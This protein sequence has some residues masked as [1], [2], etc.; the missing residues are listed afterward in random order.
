MPFQPIPSTTAQR[1]PKKMSN[2]KKWETSVV[3]KIALR[4]GIIDQE[5][6]QD[7]ILELEISPED[8]S[9]LEILESKTNIDAK[10]FKNLK[11]MVDFALSQDKD[12]Q[13]D[14][15]LAQILV[16]VQFLTQGQLEN[17]LLEQKRRLNQT[18]KSL[19]LEHIL[20]EKGFISEERLQSVLQMMAK[21]PLQ[22]EECGTKY[23]WGDFHNTNHARCQKCDF[24]LVPYLEEEMDEAATLVADESGVQNPPSQ[25]SIEQQ[26]TLAA[27]ETAA[28]D[29]PPHKAVRASEG[30]STHSPAGTDSHD[31][32]NLTSAET[33]AGNKIDT[34]DPAAQTSGGQKGTDPFI[35]QVLGEVKL[36]KK[37]GQ[38]GMGAVYLGEHLHLARQEAIKIL[39][40]EFANNPEQVTRF[41]R[42]ARAAGTLD[43]PHI[44]RVHH[45]GEHKGIHYISMEF[46]KGCSLQ[47]IVNEKK[48][49][50]AK[51][52]IEYMK[53]AAKGLIV[54]HKKDIVHRDIKPD[55]LMVTE[56]GVVKVADF[57]LARKT[58]DTMGVTQ[59]GS[60]LGTPYFM[61]P[62][63]C[64]GE[65]TDIR[66]DI[67]SLG[68]T[69]YY[70]LT[71]QHPFV[72]DSPM[73]ILL[74][75]IHEEVP[76][77][78]KFA[79]EVPDSLKN[80]I[81][82]M[83]EKL[84]EDRYQTLEEFLEDIKKLEEGEE[85]AMSEGKRRRIFRRR[86]RRAIAFALFVAVVVFLFS[87]KPGQSEAEIR[88]KLYQEKLQQAQQLLTAGDLENAIEQFEDARKQQNTSEIRHALLK[89]Y[90]Q[91]LK[92]L[93][94]KADQ[95][96][97][98]LPKTKEKL[99]QLLQQAKSILRKAQNI[100]PQFD[101][102]SEEKRL[103][104]HYLLL[105]QHQIKSAQK[106][107]PLLKKK[108]A[109][110]TR[111]LARLL[112]EEAKK[113]FQEARSLKGDK[114]ALAQSHQKIFSLFIPLIASFL[115]DEDAKNA[116]STLNQ[117]K[118]FY[119]EGQKTLE[120]WEAK[121]QQLV[122]LKQ[123]RALLLKAVRF[124]QP[125]IST[126]SP[127][128][129]P[130]IK[131]SLPK[132]SELQLNN[133]EKYANQAILK[134]PNYSLAAKVRAMLRSEQQRRLELRKQEQAR[135]KRKEETTKKAKGYLSLL[136]E[137][138]KT[139]T[140]AQF[141]LEKAQLAL[142]QLQTLIAAYQKDKFFQE[143]KNLEKNYLFHQHYFEIAQTYQNILAKIQENF[144]EDRGK[145]LGAL[146]LS[147]QLLQ[148]LNH[149]PKYQPFANYIPTISK[150]LQSIRMRLF[151]TYKEKAE[152]IK[153]IDKEKAKIY[154]KKALSFVH[155]DQ[156]VIELLA[157]LNT[158]ENMVYI[159][160]GEYQRFYEDLPPNT[161]TPEQY[162][163]LNS[164]IYMGKYEVTNQ[165]Y[166]QFVKAG[167]YNNPKFW[168]PQGWALFHGKTKIYKPWPETW[169]NGKYPAG[170]ERF[171]VSG[172]SYCEAEA[173]CRWKSLTLPGTRLPTHWEWEAAAGFL[174]QKN[175]IFKASLA[176]LKELEAKKIS[177]NFLKLLSE[178][179]N[180]ALQNL[181]V[182]KSPLA[183]IWFLVDKSRNLQLQIVRENQGLKVYKIVHRRAQYPLLGGKWKAD[184]GQIITQY[185]APRPVG[186]WRLDVSLTGCYD[187]AGNVSEWVKRPD[188]RNKEEASF[189]GASFDS[190][191]PKVHAHVTYNEFIA[192]K[193]DRFEDVGF[194]ICVD[195]STY[196]QKKET[197]RA[198]K[199]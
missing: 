166:F 158:P 52:A 112:I 136:E 76:D 41:K 67:Y 115:Q 14:V 39:P 156:S 24:A 109:E 100:N 182:T 58:Q 132:V 181:T 31:I 83:M 59:S 114:L 29:Q 23:V 174:Q 13:E 120:S 185:E 188:L 141:P 86:L 99:V 88:Q 140:L 196:L 65:K 78:K 50:D 162:F 98:Q 126:L 170:T 10:T 74:K 119:P 43:S 143:A 12:T 63:Q 26:D 190:T 72:G 8:S 113:Y 49:L 118:K 154:V 75:H 45:I 161:T 101:L 81:E 9:L 197:K 108:G 16:D 60:I 191:N 42:E 137:I 90:T 168:S 93:L 172:I 159:P 133:A 103:F 30:N 195:T 94:K 36:I 17:A 3:S 46:V 127:S 54:A 79:P 32:G 105:A 62:E 128:T 144:L 155:D 53:Q 57:G 92:N 85:I 51:E 198:K 104:Q 146:S 148:Q 15:L 37:L 44:V 22:C 38:G 27:N 40:R 18:G 55:N 35:G 131:N 192:S 186:K 151:D 80:I 91:L 152:K 160:A 64:R 121:I 165:E 21:I 169:Q 173:Y 150:T 135:L 77:I 102:S 61:S 134:S 189:K 163:R 96:A 106:L 6:L 95:Q 179:S 69:F 84:P 110:K 164:S 123:A 153:R 66:S 107:F 111:N 11:A 1:E 177:L 2:R 33:Y 178:K 171:P 34:G 167:G 68:A 139:H 149:N 71:G 184:F 73:T 138:S 28:A 116:Q 56:E 124:I 142:K 199:K 122:L 125:N 97:P 194:R 176:Y 82:K 175:Y 5:T 117:A 89:S 187:M 25:S 4:K 180:L 70:I 129:L 147:K 183:P 157:E 130:S 7:C 20:V 47:D 145:N 48:K 87:Y 19:K 193:S